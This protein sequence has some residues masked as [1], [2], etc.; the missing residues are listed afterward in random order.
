MKRALI[1]LAWV[2]LAAAL[3]AQTPA[4]APQTPAPVTAIR[5]GRLLDPDAGVVRP[6]QIILIQGNRIRD[7][8][9]N[10]AIPPGATVIDLVDDD[11]DAGPR[12]RAQ[13]SGADLQADPGEQRLL[14]HLRPGVDG[15]ARDSGGVERHPDARVRFHHRPRHGQQRELRGHGAETGDRAGLDSR[16]R[17]SST[18]ESSSAAWADSS[19]RRPRWRRTTT[20]CIRSTSTRTRPMRSSRRSA[21]TC[22][23]ARA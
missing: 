1:P 18:P 3:P 13:P 21:R 14:L 2:C 23:S 20:S 6:N 10:V 9:P 16:A 8:G 12:R 19:S 4:P 17:R 11:G 5:A 22:S 7:V 15:P